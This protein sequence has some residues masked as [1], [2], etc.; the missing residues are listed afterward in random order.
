MGAFLADITFKLPVSF[1]GLVFGLASLGEN[2]W[3]S[4]QTG[5]KVEPLSIGVAALLAVLSLIPVAGLD[6][7]QP[8]GFRSLL[9]GVCVITGILFVTLGF[10]EH[11]RL[12]K[13]LPLPKE[14]NHEQR[15]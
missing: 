10:W 7:W 1:I 9:F 14:A 6:W 3:I 2:L 5:V 11:A 13:L 12:V 4:R 8:I 15:V